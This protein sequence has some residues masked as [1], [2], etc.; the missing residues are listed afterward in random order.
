MQWGGLQ[1]RPGL[2]A[3]LL[4]LGLGDDIHKDF[5]RRNT[6][7]QIIVFG[8]GRVNLPK[9]RQKH[10]AQAQGAETAW[11]IPVGGHIIADLQAIYRRTTGFQNGHDIRLRVKDIGAAAG[12]HP[13]ARDL[14]SRPDARRHHILIFRA[15]P[16]EDRANLKQ[17]QVGIAAPGIALC[18][19]QQIGQDRRAHRV[20]IG[21]DRI[22]QGQDLRIA[23]KGHGI[24]LRQEGPGH[25]L[26]HATLGQLLL[27]KGDAALTQGQDRLGQGG[28]PFQRDR[29]DGI[30]ALHPQHFFDQALFMFDIIAPGWRY[31]C[32]DIAIA[33]CLKAQTIQNRLTFFRWDRQTAKAF[34]PI[35]AQG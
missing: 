35:G 6:T 12:F 9:P 16:P 27:G 5:K 1:Q 32:D 25:G 20:Q 14:F 33:R 8:D 10:R 13:M 23:T 28:F 11:M 24:S 29:R 19:G 30:K 15:T 4:C 2:A 26:K 34:Q 31:R 22:G 7:A 17:G 3:A 18:R 21:A